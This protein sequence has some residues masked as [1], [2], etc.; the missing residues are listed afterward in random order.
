MKF[1]PGPPFRVVVVAFWTVEDRRGVF[2]AVEPLAFSCASVFHHAL[3]VFYPAG[4]DSGE[5]RREVVEA[6]QAGEL[7]HLDGWGL[8]VM[9]VPNGY[10]GVSGGASTREALEGF[11]RYAAKEPKQVT[12]AARPS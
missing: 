3:H 9:F 2:K 1:T 5:Q 8:Q 10:Q 6:L 4:Y 7:V 11:Y 12:F